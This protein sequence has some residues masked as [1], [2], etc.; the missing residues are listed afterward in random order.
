MGIAAMT[1]GIVGLFAWIFPVLGFP[2]SIVGLILGILALVRKQQKNRAIAGIIM[3]SIGLLL[4]IG[5]VV[6]LVMLGGILEELL[7]QLMDT[8]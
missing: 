8:Y 7:P 3:C 4:N 6:G 2:T 5:F 1:L